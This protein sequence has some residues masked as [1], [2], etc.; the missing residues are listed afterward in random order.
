MDALEKATLTIY[1]LILSPKTKFQ[2]RVS[3]N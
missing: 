3:P 2:A 1:L